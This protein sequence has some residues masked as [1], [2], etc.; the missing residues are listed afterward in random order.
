MNDYKKMPD[1]FNCGGYTWDKIKED[2]DKV[3]YLCAEIIGE[4]EFGGN[5]NYAESDVRDYL[6]SNHLLRSL[7]LKFGDRL[8]PITTDLTSSTR[9]TFGKVEGDKL[10]LL[11][12][13]LFTECKDITDISDCCYFL[14]TPYSCS[15]YGS[16]YVWCV[17]PGENPGYKEYDELAS[18]RP[19]CIIQSSTEKEKIKST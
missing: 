1:S 18:V 5:N 2:A 8:L 9:E 6:N 17:R 16:E 7:E 15:G 3:Y 19:F 11:T 13:D 12:L 10:S 4:M 14:A